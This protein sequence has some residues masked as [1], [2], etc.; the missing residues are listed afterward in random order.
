MFPIKTS[1]GVYI[2]KTIQY[3]GE[4]ALIMLMNRFYLLCK[5]AF[6]QH[7]RTMLFELLLLYYY[8]LYLYKNKLFKIKYIYTCH[9]TN[10]HKHAHTL[11][12]KLLNK[13]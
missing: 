2:K 1:I 6:K 7:A 13:T 8:F 12:N 5:C 10:T 9:A 3:K 4:L 11:L